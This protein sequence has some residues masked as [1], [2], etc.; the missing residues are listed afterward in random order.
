[1]P[2]LRSDGQAGGLSRRDKAHADQ[3]HAE[4]ALIAGGGERAVDADFYRRAL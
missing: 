3:N 4:G 1:M 2:E